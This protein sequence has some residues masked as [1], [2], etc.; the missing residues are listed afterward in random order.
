ML[1]IIAKEK[2]WHVEQTIDEVSPGDPNHPE[3]EDTLG[4]VSRMVRNWEAFVK[5]DHEPAGLKASRRERKRN[6]FP[7]A[8][9]DW[10]EKDEE[11]G[12]VVY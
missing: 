6:N 9:E 5:G 8:E 3:G 2:G 12:S 1:E 7:H 11:L 4:A 10:A